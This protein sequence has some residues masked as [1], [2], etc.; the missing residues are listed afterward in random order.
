MSASLCERGYY[1]NAIVYSPTWAVR[2]VSLESML[3]RVE[4]RKASFGPTIPICVQEGKLDIKA[5][6][7]AIVRSGAVG[8]VSHAA[9]RVYKVSALDVVSLRV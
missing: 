2:P 7:L 8:R 9:S 3:L 6:V 1:A 5:S 4:E